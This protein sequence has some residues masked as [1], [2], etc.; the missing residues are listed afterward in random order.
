MKSDIDEIADLL[1]DEELAEQV[2]Q[3]NSS[4]VG[5]T[6][7]QV[8]AVILGIIQFVLWGVL[9]YVAPAALIKLCLTYLL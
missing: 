1:D 5:A 3:N 9:A 7:V 6:I 8:L 2:K 4:G